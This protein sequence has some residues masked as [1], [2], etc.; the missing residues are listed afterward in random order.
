MCTQILLQVT[1]PNRYLYPPVHTH[2]INHSQVSAQQQ[3]NGYTQCGLCT[4]WNIIQPY[5]GKEG[6][7]GGVEVKVL[8]PT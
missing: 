2:L 6:P 8:S 7:T 3:M 4:Q 5:K 1:Y